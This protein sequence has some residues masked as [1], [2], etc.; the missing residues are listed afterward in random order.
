MAYAS[1]VDN[2]IDPVAVDRARRCWDRERLRYALVSMCSGSGGHV[3]VVA[4]VGCTSE[5]SVSSASSADAASSSSAGAAAD[6]PCAVAQSAPAG[7][8]WR[9]WF[10][11]G[12]ATA[13][14][15]FGSP[16]PSIASVLASRRGVLGDCLDPRRPVLDG[17]SASNAE[18]RLRQGDRRATCRRGRHIR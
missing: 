6:R 13:W 10:D 3:A 16:L 15:I 17:L 12:L 9:S 14:L 18:D 1:A 8:R 7:H 4:M 5:R 11:D 2:F